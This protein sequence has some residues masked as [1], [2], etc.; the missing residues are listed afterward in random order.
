MAE[1]KKSKF[2][3]LLNNNKDNRTSAPMPFEFMT[4]L[5]NANSLKVQNKILDEILFL[6]KVTE[7]NLAA[8]RRLEKFITGRNVKDA[9]KEEERKYVASFMGQRFVRG[10]SLAQDTKDF[11]KG[12]K[13]PFTDKL[14]YIFGLNPSKSTTQSLSAA[15]GIDPTSELLRRKNNEELA[16][17]IAEKLSGLLG[18][19]G[20]SGSIFPDIIA[21]PG[22]KNPTPNKTGETKGKN[23]PKNLMPV[24]Q[25]ESKITAPATPSES[26]KPV[27]QSA[28]PK[29][30][31]PKLTGPQDILDADR[32]KTS[33][34]AKPSLSADKANAITM[35]YDPKKGAYVPSNTNDNFAKKVQS[36][37]MGTALPG[38]TVDVDNEK[39]LKEQT[40]IQGEIKGA[41]PSISGDTGISAGQKPGGSTGASSSGIPK[42]ATG[43]KLPAILD[44]AVA[45]YNAYSTEKDLKEGK[46]DRAEAQRQHGGTAGGFLGGLGGAAAG[47]MIGQAL[48]PIPG[49]GFV[50]GSLAGGLL[51]NLGGNKA[52]SSAVEAVQKNMPG[53]LPGD[54]SP[55]VNTSNLSNM[56]EEKMKENEGLKYQQQMMNRSMGMPVG[57]INSVSQTN[58][59]SSK[60]NVMAARARPDNSDQTFRYLFANSVTV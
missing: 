42:W 19:L 31:Y 17:L 10:Q 39:I 5:S 27:V 4:A 25:G 3:N 60:T 59:D 46:I 45:G 56:M 1:D 57:G 29:T 58:I 41:G 7:Q 18:N 40:R 32:P 14:K 13:D 26:T 34:N 52:G 9:D 6:K 2:S 8:N 51:G 28:G 36:S 23:Q 54:V 16:E 33:V 43:W 12:M 21:G 38:S 11:I 50:V 53:I 15:S 24:E 20:D 55:Q 48:I 37:S 49:V 22:K 44:A 30:D 47:G 35:E